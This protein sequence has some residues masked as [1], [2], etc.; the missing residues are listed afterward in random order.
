M[1]SASVKIETSTRLNRNL[2]L[3]QAGSAVTIDISTPAGQ[4]GKFRSTFVGYLPKQYVL[5][6]F[7]ES[8][9]LGNFGQYIVQGA[10]VTVRG[11]IE[12]QEGSV[13][14]FISTIKQTIQI[15]S[16]LMVL[17]FPKNLSMQSL[18]KSIRIETDIQSKILIDKNF[19]QGM[20]TDLS[21]NGCQLLIDNGETL[22]LVKDKSIDIVIENFLDLKNLK[23]AGQICSIK[24]VLN[25]VSLGVKFNESSKNA[26]VKLLHHV[27]TIEV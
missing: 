7:P 20:I 14:A 3:M 18:R 13:A 23:L 6:Q 10:G 22:N 26:V 24:P 25:G 5:L 1:S 2:G 27:V 9:K 11:I 16:K 8:N 21:L 17:D 12:G 19:W 15:P 4:K